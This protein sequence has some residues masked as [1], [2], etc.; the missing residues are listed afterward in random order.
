MLTSELIKAARMLLRWD[1][2]RLAAESGVAPVTIKRIEAAD[3]PIKTKASTAQKILVTLQAAGIEFIE[4]D[5]AHGAGV[6]FKASQK[7]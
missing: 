7:A 3:G 2:M 5:G 4:D 1:Q 6:R